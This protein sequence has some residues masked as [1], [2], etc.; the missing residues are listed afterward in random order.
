MDNILGRQDWNKNDSKELNHHEWRQDEKF[1]MV[2]RAR[3][4]SFLKTFCIVCDCPEDAQLDDYHVLSLNELNQD[5][6]RV[7]KVTLM[8][9]HLKIMVM[10][11]A[12]RTERHIV[13]KS[14]F[15]VRSYS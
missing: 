13:S 8:T 9:L 1:G 7:Q 6:F 10:R 4:S 11:P 5:S 15:R 3:Y 14:Y 2:I 12:Y